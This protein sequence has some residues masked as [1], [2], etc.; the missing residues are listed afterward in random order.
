MLPELSVSAYYSALLK[1]SDSDD[2][3]S[4]LTERF[5]RARW[6][7]SCLE[8]RRGTLLACA[9]EIVR[10]QADY[11]SGRRSYLAP[12]GL[13]DVAARLEMHPSTV[14]RAIRG[15]YLQFGGTVSAMKSLFSRGVGAGEG[16][17]S[18]A[19]AAR[20]AIRRFVVGED[21]RHPLSDQRLCELLSR[22]G[23]E[24]SR[25]TVAKYRG[26]LGIPGT[27]ARRER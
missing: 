20:A 8:Q 11:F 5:Q 3:R 16:E 7:M 26:E 6:L 4:Y 18:S 22:E 23:M 13:S 12:M 21:K 25:R 9:R 19:E 24:L 1:S 27:A 17:R 15:K 10:L 14:S 2:V